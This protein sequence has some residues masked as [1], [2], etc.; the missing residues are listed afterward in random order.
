M[1]LQWFCEQ[2]LPTSAIAARYFITAGVSTLS[3]IALCIFQQRT[4]KR[5][6]SQGP[7]NSSFNRSAGNISALTSQIAIGAAEVS[8]FVD[9]VNQ[10]IDN[11]GEYASRIAVAAE[12]LNQTTK[13][14]GDNAKHVLEQAR[15]AQQLSQNGKITT[16]EGYR[17]IVQ[18]SKDVDTAASQLLALKSSADQIRNITSLIGGVAEQ[19]NLLA[20]NA[21]IEAARAGEHGRGFAVVADEVR[22][23]AAKS[24]QATNDIE[25][26][27]AN[28]HNE[29]DQT[30]AL[31]QQ[32]V[33]QTSSVVEAMQKLDEGFGDISS[34][35]DQSTDAIGH[36]ESALQEQA[37]TT[38]DI[39][40]SI[41]QVRDSLTHTGSRSKDISS[42]AYSLSQTTEGIFTE[43]GDWETGTFEQQVLEEANSAALRCGEELANGLLSG[44]F[45]ERDLFDP[46]YEEQSGTNPPKYSTPFDELTDKLFPAIQEP[47][48]ERNPQIIYAG[49][50]DQRGYFPTHNRRFSQILTGDYQL[51]MANNRT[52]RIFDDPTGIRC[53]KH[54][55]KVL[56]QTYKRDTGEVMH[57][58]SVPIFVNERHWG[59][60]RIGFKASN[61]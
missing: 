24:A 28:I 6:L 52:K 33:E 61:D 17:S 32:V 49:A 23:L 34:S 22:A 51:D 40:S 15:H 8:H 18:L 30:S 44:Q 20:L 42:Q 38:A 9:E 35:I 54:T 46:K 39:S 27:L 7:D 1:F 26:M 21:A 37:D 41:N 4:L 50:V 47:I 58:L 36:I 5:V 10:S 16:Q 13:S 29:T 59:G 3:I 14:L 60:F 31:M 11:N 43:L 2:L 19:T 12:Q 56:L 48:L 25:S 45:T 57:D 55:D 53:G